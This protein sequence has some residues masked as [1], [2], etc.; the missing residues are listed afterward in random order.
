MSKNMICSVTALGPKGEK[1]MGLLLTPYKK[2]FS[3]EGADILRQLQC[4]GYKDKPW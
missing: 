1:A 3:P 4:G 2:A